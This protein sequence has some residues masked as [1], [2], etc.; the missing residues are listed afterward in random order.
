MGSER[1]V[2]I[3]SG[4]LQLEGA[5][6]EGDGTLASLVLH[7]H[8]QYGGDMHNHVVMAVCDATA[9]VGATTLRFNF[10][11]TGRSEG[12]HSRGPGEADDARAAAAFLRAGAPEAKL[13]VTGYSFGA[14]IAAIVAADIRPDALALVSPPVGMMELPAIDAALPV[15]VAAGDRDQVVSVEE[16]RA[17]AG[18][19]R[20]IFIA[21]GVDHG[22]WPGLDGLTETITSFV[23]S[24]LAATA[25]T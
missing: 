21:P 14:M 3:H 2:T 15:L 12:A 25:A 23:K 19:N 4:G 20:T 17:L 7:P 10:R 11:G 8:P 24:T 9:A 1:A 22:W 18:P 6:R 16:V 13:L 5:I